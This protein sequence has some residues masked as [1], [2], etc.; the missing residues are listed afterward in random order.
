MKLTIPL[1]TYGLELATIVRDKFNEQRNKNPERSPMRLNAHILFRGRGNRLL[2]KRT[3]GEEI[4]GEPENIKMYNPVKYKQICSYGGQ[5]DIPL[6]YAQRV[7]LY[8]IIDLKKQFTEWLRR[9]N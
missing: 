1:G 6:K 7:S 4:K 5:K 2:Y 8:L 3:G 9:I